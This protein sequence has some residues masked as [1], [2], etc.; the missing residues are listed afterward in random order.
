MKLEGE[1][2]K[3]RG[4]SCNLFVLDLGS[5]I[6]AQ[7]AHISDLILHDKRNIGRDAEADSAGKRCSLREETKITQSERQCDGLLKV[8]DDLVILLRN[9]LQAITGK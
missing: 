1:I 3:C 7:M 9:A 5:Q 2:T 8:D 6:E 4:L